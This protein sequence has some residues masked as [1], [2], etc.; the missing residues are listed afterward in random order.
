M[1]TKDFIKQFID[2]NQAEFIAASDKI[3]DLAEI[4]FACPKSAEVLK[5]LLRK[6]NFSI[7][8]ELANVPNSFVASFG[9]GGLSVGILAE[10]DALPAL[11]QT[12]D[13]SVKDQDSSGNGHGC[14]HNAIGAG[15]VTAAIAL[16]KALEKYAL[17][18]RVLLFGC[19]AEEA[20]SAKAYMAANGVFDQ[21]DFIL[22]WHPMENSANWGR[23][24]LANSQLFFRFKGV[25]SHAGQ[26]PELGRSALDAAELMNVGTQFLREHV[27]DSVR[28]HYAFLDAGGEAANTVQPTAELLY[29]IRA[30][31]REEVSSITQRVIKIAEGA[32]LMSDVAWEYEWDSAA[33]NYLVNQNLEH[34]MYKNLES[35]YPLDYTAEDYAYMKAFH[36]SLSPYVLEANE[37]RIR[38]AFA[39]LAEEELQKIIQSPIA[40]RLFPEAYSSLPMTG[41]TDVGDASWIKPMAQVIIAYGPNGSNPHSWQWVATGK[42][43]V[44]H[45]AL[46]TA[47][48]TIAMTAWDVMKNPEILAKAQVEHEKILA[49]REYRSLNPKVYE[50][51][52]A[53]QT[54]KTEV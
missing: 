40:D 17:P 14:G 21:T 19:P 45:L 11:S 29:I 49:G 1:D 35:L 13:V 41:S 43:H 9:E 24:S 27:S 39:D 22:T 36:E 20:G 33:S 25:S 10:Y 38:S 34:V 47:G 53:F 50:G 44:A 18:G 16:A 54:Q 51:A 3:W 4:K 42:S 12:A 28:I 30:K 31:E 23:S 15:A 5:E 6:Y 37:K 52:K 2:E 46:L 32:A 48:K 7:E 26:A 8:D